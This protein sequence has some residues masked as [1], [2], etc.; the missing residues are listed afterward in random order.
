MFTYKKL[1]DGLVYYQNIIDDPYKII[2]DIE[3]LNDKVLLQLKETPDL[4]MLTSVRPWHN[5]DH[6]QGDMNL[7]FCKQRWLPRS[8][9][10]FSEDI[11]YSEHASISDRLFSALDTALEHYST[12]L[13]PYAKTNIKG[14]EDNMS[15]LKYEKAGYLPNHI[16]SG[17]S[18][19]TLSVVLY[20]N[21]NYDGGEITF[22]NVGDGVTV[23]PTA[24]SAIF[25][26]SNYVF[27]H[28][29]GEVSNGIRY[30]LPNWYHNMETKI[31]TDGGA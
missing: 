10:M 11:Y 16:D 14:K 18:S 29:V 15:I 26:P 12:E 28:E 20:L 17:S 31:Y 4:L 30:A 27:A 2:E 5:W 3:L 1:G 23:K 22:P 13:Y 24:G 19:R 25:F 9:D 6:S 21:D 8:S 7:H